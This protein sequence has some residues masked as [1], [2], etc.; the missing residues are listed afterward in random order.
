MVTNYFL[1]FFADVKIDRLYSMLSHSNEISSCA[2]RR[3]FVRFS[4][5]TLEFKT[6]ICTTGVDNFTTLS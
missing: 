4:S 1:G 3:N 5:V 6:I 2:L